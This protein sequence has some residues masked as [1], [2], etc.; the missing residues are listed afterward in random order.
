L[1]LHKLRAIGVQTYTLCIDSKVIA[2]QIE[3][4]CITREPT[5]KRYLTLIRRMES[6]LRGFTVEYIERSKNFEDDELAMAAARN[7]P[8]H[9][10]VFF[11]V[12]L[13]AS[14]KIVETEPRVV[15]LIDGEEWHAP[16]MAYLHH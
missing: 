14:I 8:L 15:N 6:Y 3:K 1:E 13:D 16:I 12:I 10:N 2:S 4:E 9:A 5:L 11:Q 7:T